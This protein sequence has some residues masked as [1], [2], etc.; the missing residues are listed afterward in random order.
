M[1]PHEK[2]IKSLKNKVDEKEIVEALLP[3]ENEGT[4]L[5]KIG[6]SKDLDCDGKNELFDGIYE[7]SKEEVIIDIR[8]T[9]HILDEK[10]LEELVPFWRALTETYN[11]PVSPVFIVRPK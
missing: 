4:D 1:E 2:I 8:L 3:E 10:E 7:D 11:K 5:R 6:D 9:D